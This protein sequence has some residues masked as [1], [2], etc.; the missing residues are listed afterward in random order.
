[1]LEFRAFLLL[2]TSLEL[3]GLFYAW[4]I[5][6]A[7]WEQLW[8]LAIETFAYGCTVMVPNAPFLRL[9]LKNGVTLPWLRFVGWLLTCPVLL[10]GLV[11]LT[12]V[13]GRPAT[14]RLV[15]LL[16]ANISMIL[17]GITAAA[18]VDTGLRNIIFGFA[19]ASGG[20]VFISAAQ[21]FHA[22]FSYSQNRHTTGDHGQSLLRRTHIIGVMHACAFFS[23]W[24][25]FPLGYSL[26]P[27]YA[28]LISASSETLIFVFGDLLSK[29]IFVV[30]GVAFKYYFLA[31]WSPSASSEPS[32]PRVVRRPSQIISSEM[33]TVEA[34]PGTQN[35]LAAQP[36]TASEV[37]PRGTGS[38]RR[39]AELSPIDVAA[40]EETTAEKRGVSPMSRT[41]YSPL[42]GQGEPRPATV[43]NARKLGKGPSWC[44]PYAVARTQPTDA[45]LPT[46]QPQAALT[47]ETVAIASGI[48]AALATLESGTGAAGTRDGPAPPDQVTQALR[49]IAEHPDVVLSSKDP[50]TLDR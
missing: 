3:M 20:M 31:A 15:P 17:L 2:V 16:V 13:D 8:V 5:K 35:A 34:T 10:M 25:L 44:S 7:G 49:Y 24:L 30:T 42:T 21:C 26:G 14:V 11:S 47:P 12:T 23:G 37:P 38:I 33:V 1:M 48:A 32:P 40:T 18:V 43:G 4:R 6:L 39:I 19:L 41:R 36:R 22:L 50:A 45:P 29:N 9:E 46:P 27:L 28:G